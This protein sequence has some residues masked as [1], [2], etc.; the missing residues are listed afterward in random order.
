MM[1]EMK[2]RVWNI[3]FYGIEM[4]CIENVPLFFF[5]FLLL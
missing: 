1:A 3:T 4:M 2:A 5:L